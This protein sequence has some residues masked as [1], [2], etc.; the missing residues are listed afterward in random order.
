M[1]SQSEGA[2]ISDLLSIEEARSILMVLTG[3]GG[4]LVAMAVGVRLF[5]VCEEDGSYV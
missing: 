5:K 4:K 1:S 3:G 2:H